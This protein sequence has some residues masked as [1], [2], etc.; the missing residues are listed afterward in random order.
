MRYENV[1]SLEGERDSER[2]T[3]AGEKEQKVKQ[4]FVKLCAR[5][6]KKGTIQ[7]LN[8]Q[9]S[10]LIGL[11][12]LHTGSPRQLSANRRTGHRTWGGKNK[13]KNNE[14]K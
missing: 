6:E 2:E 7:I 12:Y 13:E 10:Q 14:E 5:R 3:S 4:D 9:A 11:T 1:C 8:E